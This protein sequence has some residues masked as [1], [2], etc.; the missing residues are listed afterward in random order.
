MMVMWGRTI[1]SDN[2][3]P[4]VCLTICLIFF[5]SAALAGA[6]ALLNAILVVNVIALHMR[7]YRTFDSVRVD[8]SCLD[9]SKKFGSEFKIGYR[10]K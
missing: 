10:I 5:K 4:S 3:L 6:R 9:Y 1:V 8:S 2:F 7:L